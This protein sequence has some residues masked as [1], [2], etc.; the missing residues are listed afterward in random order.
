MELQ[1]LMGIAKMFQKSIR[2]HKGRGQSLVEFTLVLPIFVLLL[3]A[4]GYI[5]IA[6]YQG[7]MAS[8]AIREPGIHKMEMANEKGAVSGGQLSGYVSSSPIGGSINM[9]AKVDSVSV[10]NGQNAAIIVGTKNYTPPVS[11]IP[12]FNFAVAQAIN[13]NLLLAANG[14][15]AKVRSIKAPF[16]PGGG[17]PSATSSLALVAGSTVDTAATVLPVAPVVP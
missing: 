10:V 11:F 16:V 4:A 9:G 14:G 7:S 5:G 3:V 13:A 12:S 17:I 8:D 6:L 2:R 1:N 15:G